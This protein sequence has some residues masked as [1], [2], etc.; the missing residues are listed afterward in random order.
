M[1]C[2]EQP[3]LAYTNFRTSFA[4]RSNRAC[5]WLPFPC[6]RN[7]LRRICVNRYQRFAGGSIKPNR[8]G[9]LPVG[10]G[11]FLCF[12]V[13]DDW[14]DVVQSAVHAVDLE[15]DPEFRHA[16]ALKSLV[17]FLVEFNSSQGCALICTSNGQR[18]A[19]VTQGWTE[20]P[21]IGVMHPDRYVEREG[22]PYV[23]APYVHRIYHR[24]QPDLTITD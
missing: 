5:F 24:D 23:H 7:I 17:L 1:A 3:G 15:F 10:R 13:G 11:Q 4:R 14:M 18:V 20:I 6:L 19:C 8:L 2:A 9:C 22:V 16:I 12:P 21:I